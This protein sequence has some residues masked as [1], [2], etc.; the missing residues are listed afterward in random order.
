MP[1]SPA[2]P[3]PVSGGLQFAPKQKTGEIGISFTL[4]FWDGF[5][6]SRTLLGRKKFTIQEIQVEKVV[7]FGDLIAIADKLI[8]RRKWL[9]KQINPD[10]FWVKTRQM[11]EFNYFY[12]ESRIKNNWPFL[13]E[14]IIALEAETVLRQKRKTITFDKNST[15][16]NYRI[17]INL[18][19]Q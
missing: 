14:N 4:D 2:S 9:I 11:F 7:D 13:E 3:R 18:I 12:N 17:A 16:S 19:S 8:K 5:D 10:D 6:S 15:C 1:I